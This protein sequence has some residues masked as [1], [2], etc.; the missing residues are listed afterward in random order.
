MSDTQGQW[1]AEYRQMVD[2]NL[3]LLADEQ[4]ERLRAAKVSVFG[5]GGIG[6]TAFEVLVRSGI[7][8]L[9]VIDQDV[10]DATNLNRQVLAVHET[11]GQRKIDVAED[12]ARAINPDVVIKKYET[13]TEDNIEQILTGSCV[14][15]MGIDSLMPCVIIS[16]KA[17]ELD[18]P[19]VEGWALPYGN[20][21]VLTSQTPSLEE[22]YGLPSLGKPLSEFSEDDFKAMG[23]ELLLGLGNI[24]GLMELI[25]E[26]VAENV[27]AGRNPS[28][29]PLVW[30]PAV[31]MALETIKIILDWG[32]LAL[33]PD[34]A[35]YDPLHHKIPG[36]DTP[37][38]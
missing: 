14:A 8:Q 1:S 29:C 21:R 3:G 15:V 17:R 19:M 13:P 2:R 9:D 20:V 31:L 11:V 37:G 10:F 7:G 26:R 34:F 24:P 35:L 27:A 22:I 18:I 4:Q 28:F 25:P 33:A 16:R 36:A 32:E 30:L 23:V 6:G 12:R 5:M 38:D